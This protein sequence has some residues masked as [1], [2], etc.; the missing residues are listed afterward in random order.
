M[1]AFYIKSLGDT[2]SLFSHQIRISN[3]KKVL[4]FL[5]KDL[6][7]E[8]LTNKNY[9]ESLVEWLPEKLMNYSPLQKAQYIEMKTLL[10][11]YLLSSQGDRMSMAHSIEGRYPFLDHNVIELFSRMPDDIKLKN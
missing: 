11:G 9:E 7:N 6:K 8:F 10:S 5:S 1:K 3:G 4:D 2:N